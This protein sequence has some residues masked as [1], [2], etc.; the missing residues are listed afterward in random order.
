MSRAVMWILTVQEGMRKSPL[1]RGCRP[2]WETCLNECLCADTFAYLCF[3]RIGFQSGV[4]VSKE[5]LC[6]FKSGQVFLSSLQN[7]CIAL[8]SHPHLSEDLTAPNLLTAEYYQLFFIVRT[9][10]SDRS[11]IVTE[12]SHVLCVYWSFILFSVNFLFWSQLISPELLVYFFLG[13][14]VLYYTLH[15]QS[16]LSLPVLLASDL[17]SVVSPET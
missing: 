12:F 14:L 15:I 9:V 4:A 6:L 7:N 8:D 5:E 2:G 17:M 1:S 3:C 10:I 16:F 11:L 13:E